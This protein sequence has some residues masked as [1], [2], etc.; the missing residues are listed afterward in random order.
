MNTDAIES[1]KFGRV[2]SLG[3]PYPAARALWVGTE[4]NVNVRFR[5]GGT[6][7]YQAVKGLLPVETVEVL[8]ES[9]TASAITTI[10]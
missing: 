6:V 3:T 1:G 4:G 5:D 7:V 8:S 2:V 9:T 10:E